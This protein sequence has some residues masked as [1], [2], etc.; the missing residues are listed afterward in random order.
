[1]EIVRFARK[2]LQPPRRDFKL[3]TLLVMKYA[4]PQLLKLI[5]NRL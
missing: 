5:V 1:M 3:S 2:E 4:L